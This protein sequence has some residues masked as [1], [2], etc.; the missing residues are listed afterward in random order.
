MLA[1]LLSI[2]QNEIQK[3]WVY[4]W[5][6]A[7]I[8]AVV[9]IAG[10]AY[11]LHEPNVYD[12]WGQL[13]VVKPTTL[14]AATQ[15]VSLGGAS[16]SE[17]SEQFGYVAKPKVV[18]S[19]ASIESIVRE[20][21]ASGKSLSPS[22]V[23]E[24][25]ATIRRSV[26]V[27]NID[28]NGFV[29]FHAKSSDPAEAQKVAELLMK[30]FITL[31][32]G[33][34]TADLGLTKGF[35]VEQLVNYRKQIEDS[36]TKLADFRRQHPGLPVIASDTGLAVPAEVNEPVPASAGVV[37]TS[38]P[39]AAASA[40]PPLSE[41][42]TAALAADDQKV[43]DLESQLATLKSQ[44]T[45]Q[46]P[47]VIVAKR[48]LGQALAHR[49]GLQAALT[50]IRPVAPAKVATVRRVVHR[51]TYTPA[52][53]PEVATD[54]A[55]LQAT[56]QNLRTNYQQLLGRL[57]AA[58]I[59]EAAF[60]ANNS[61]RFEVTHAPTTPSSPSSLPRSAQLGLAFLVA[62]GLGLGA[63]YI[64]AAI[65]GILVSSA[66]LEEAFQLPVVGTVSWE[67]A[68]ETRPG[69]RRQS[70]VEPLIEKLKLT[71]KAS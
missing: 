35:L 39:V 16:A 46:Y 63:A 55:T 15:G 17:D 34:S 26:V 8:T 22:E 45:D 10:G 48:E 69:G 59:S 51:R 25:V 32:L 58:R 62:F 43:A 41:A 7:A 71:F 4:R 6:V 47:D 11:V 12:S 31:S 5:I 19:D 28:D 65:N 36:Q 40:S 23:S 1:N 57:E 27:G 70:P 56:D 29:E 30:R 9:F 18:L 42:A 61:T 53:S 21:N 38:A 44:Y 64:L 3:I 49:A 68:W 33:S 13:Y 67:S 50:T 14:T 37:T 54:W 2:L 24:Q 52:I 60:G 20:L 66:E